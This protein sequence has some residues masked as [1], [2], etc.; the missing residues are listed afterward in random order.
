MNADIKAKWVA[1]LRSGEYKQGKNRLRTKDSFCC[2]GVLCDLFLKDGRGG[3]WDDT[4][5][6]IS[7]DGQRFAISEDEGS[8]YG[9]PESV[10]AW[11][12]VPSGAVLVRC[13]ERSA[14]AGIDMLNDG[15]G[16]IKPRTFAELADTI[17]EQL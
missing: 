5:A 8:S 16:E 13:E 7:Y 3:K 10:S 4:L 2:L 1:A 9:L 15:V 11:A 14:V 12:G 6:G 17:E